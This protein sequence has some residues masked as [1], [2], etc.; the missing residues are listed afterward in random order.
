[1]CIARKC[2]HLPGCH[3]ADTAGVE[4]LPSKAPIDAE[5]QKIA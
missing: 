5:A 1:M 2:E 3:S 4:A